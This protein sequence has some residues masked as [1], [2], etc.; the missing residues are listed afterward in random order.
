[1][2]SE[3]SN[4]TPLNYYGGKKQLAP[5]LVRLMGQAPQRRHYAE[6]FAGGAAVLFELPLRMYQIESINDVDLRV[7]AFW[8]QFHDNPQELIKLIKKRALYSQHYH[9]QAREIWMKG[10]P[11]RMETAWS[12]FYLSRT[13][14]NSIL[15]S[16]FHYAKQSHKHD[17]PQYFQIVV[18]HLHTVIERFSRVQVFSEDA[19]K[20]IKRVDSPDTFFLVDPPYPGANQGH[21]AGYTQEMFDLLL[22]RLAVI[23]GGFILCSYPN[24]RL[25]EVARTCSWKVGSMEK[26]LSSGWVKGG[27]LNKKTEMIAH[28]IPSR[29]G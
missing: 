27:T 15:G 25:F 22:D 17:L 28:N 2:L 9:A 16:T 23:Q 10:S 21:Y 1:M 19:L 5:E 20:F 4:R 24:K 7:T 6:P 18:D 3:N 26:F 8:E 12:V 13:S 29:L 14:S 11:S